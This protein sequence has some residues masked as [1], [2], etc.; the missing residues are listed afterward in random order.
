MQQA[1]GFA[2]KSINVG[3]FVEPRGPSNERMTWA[4]FGH[5]G[6]FGARLLECSSLWD[7]AVLKPQCGACF[8]LLTPQISSHNCSPVTTKLMFGNFVIAPGLAL[9]QP[10]PF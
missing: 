5:R 9:H 7:K 3:R 10:T 2:R 4:Q 1:A 6:G 8:R